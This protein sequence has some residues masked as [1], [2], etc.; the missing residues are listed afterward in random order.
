MRGIGRSVAALA[1]LVE[2]SVG[3]CGQQ[4]GPD[5]VMP[6]CPMPLA[7]TVKVTSA[8]GG[9]VSGL[10]LTMSGAASGSGQCTVGEASTTCVVPGM[11]G[12][13]VLQLAAPGFA[14]KTLSVVVPGTTPA[15]GCTSVDVQRL[16]IVLTPS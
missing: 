4:S 11:P 7:M 13:Y 9:A 1:V 10:T 6:P 14:D 3:G 8:T 15:C 12:T 2:L 16:D 5:C